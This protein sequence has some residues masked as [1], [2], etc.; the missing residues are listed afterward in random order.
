MTKKMQQKALLCFLV[1]HFDLFD[2]FVWKGVI[3]NFFDIFDSIANF[4]LKCNRFGCVHFRSNNVKI[5]HSA[6]STNSCVTTNKEQRHVSQAKCACCSLYSKIYP[7]FSRQGWCYFWGT[8][9]QQ[10]EHAYSLSLTVLLSIGIQTPLVS[11]VSSCTK[12][13]NWSHDSERP[14]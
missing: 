10:H 6:L 11:L 3:W 5:M 12:V 1:G 13:L 2:V 9:V 14:Q 7:T 4:A 8:S